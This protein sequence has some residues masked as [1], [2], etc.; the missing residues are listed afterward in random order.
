MLGSS[1]LSCRI[2]LLLTVFAV[3]CSDTNICK[4]SFGATNS[5]PQSQLS[6]KIDYLHLIFKQEVFITLTTTHK[7]IECL[8]YIRRDALN[9]KRRPTNQQ[10]V[11]CHISAIS[12][13]AFVLVVILSFGNKDYNSLTEQEEL[14][15]FLLRTNLNVTLYEYVK[16]SL[17]LAFGPIC[18]L[19]LTLS[20]AHI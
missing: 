16:L 4:T 13:G 11:W 10:S 3:M 7:Q 19:L 2:D 9:C 14:S 1:K 17:D 20:N 12:K 15:E 8:V 6:V 18:R 5:L